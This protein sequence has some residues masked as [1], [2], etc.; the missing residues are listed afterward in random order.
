MAPSTTSGAVMSVVR[1]AAT[2]VDVFQVAMRDCS[3]ETLPTRS[4][5]AQARHIRGCPGLINEN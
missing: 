1:K 5:P 3:D 2:N 4:A